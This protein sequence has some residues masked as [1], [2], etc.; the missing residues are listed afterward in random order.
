MSLSSNAFLDV[1]D[2]IGNRLCRDAIWSD[3][4]CN[5][6]GWTFVAQGATPIP[7]YR[8]QGVALRDGIA[9]IALFLAWLHHF[10]RDPLHARTL[11]GAL[12]QL[13]RAL[14]DRGDRDA[15]AAPHADA[16]PACGFHSGTAGVAAAC[17]QIGELLRDDAWLARGLRLL[18]DVAR[19]AG[20]THARD[21]ASGAAGSIPVLLRAGARFDLPH[22]TIAATR[23]AD[24][25]LDAAR[26]SEDGPAWPMPDAGG[27]RPFLGYAH[28]VGGMACALLDLDRTLGLHRASGG[29]RYRTAAIAALRDERRHLAAIDGL[30]WSDGASSV[31]CT[32]LR[33]SELLAES[34][35]SE[36][37]AHAD[38][39]AEADA[40][41]RA[42]A[43]HLG[44]ARPWAHTFCLSR[45][46]AGCADVLLT[47]AER[48][49]RPAL[50]QAAET[51]GELGIVHFDRPRV[52]WPCGLPGIGGSP[53]LL[54]GLAGV[55]Y[56]YLR[57]HQP[58][59]V[60]TVLVLRD[61]PPAARAATNRLR[62]ETLADLVSAPAALPEAP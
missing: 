6:L 20:R 11:H 62:L 30:G 41:L 18:D 52:P 27:A 35:Q 4:R 55:G 16:L 3:G 36:R 24:V 15:A 34:N 60:P 45:G 48:L 33:A 10:T 51:L 59:V 57:L 8:A 5:W 38:V 44:D 25:L 39:D 50:R 2:R 14:A 13:D 46:L 23:Q 42:I 58:H 56:F 47:G 1:A 21:V 49:G 19:D 53:N 32:L 29:D 43:T 40:L 61:E 12:R 54:L 31:A 26:P 17:L 28:G 9:G 7:G 37:E 22:L